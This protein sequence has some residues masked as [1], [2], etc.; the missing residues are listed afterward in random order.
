MATEDQLVPIVLSG[1]IDTKTDPKSVTLDKLLLL[2]NGS[3][4]SPK[5]I[6]KRNGYTNLGNATISGGNIGLSVNVAANETALVQYA[7]NLVYAQTPARAAFAP[8]GSDYPITCKNLSLRNSFSNNDLPDYA[9]VN[10]YE[11]YSYFDSSLG[12]NVTIRDLSTS[13]ILFESNASSFPG[14]LAPKLIS[15]GSFAYLFESGTGAGGTLTITKIDPTLTSPLVTTVTAGVQTNSSGAPGPGSRPVFEDFFDAALTT[16][17][18]A[19]AFF[20]TPAGTTLEVQLYDQA[21]TLTQS[22]TLTIGVSAPT[23]FGCIGIKENPVTGEIYVVYSSDNNLYYYVLSSTLT[24]VIGPVLIYTDTSFSGV[25]QFGNVTAYPTGAN[26]MTVL[27]QAVPN[28]LPSITD[29][30]KNKIY[31]FNLSNS[32]VTFTDLTFCKQGS[33]ASKL[34]SYGGKYYVVEGYKSEVQATYYLNEVTLTGVSDINKLGMAGRFLIGTAQGPVG[35]GTRAI[36]PEVTVLNGQAF[37]GLP[38]QSSLGV[39]A[40]TPIYATTKE[41]FNFIDPAHVS[42]SSVPDG[43]IL[44]TNAQVQSFDGYNAEENFNKFP[45]APILT[46]GGAGQLD[47]GT[48]QVAVVYEWSDKLGQV[49][50]S[51]PSIPTSIT[52]PGPNQAIVVQMDNTVNTTK[53][54]PISMGVYRTIDNGTVFYR[55]NNTN[56]LSRIANSGSSVTTV[57]NVS[58]ADIQSHEILYTDGGILPNDPAPS[59]TFQWQFKNRTML[60]GLDDGNQVAYSKIQVKGEPVKFNANFFINV[61][62]AGGDTTAGGQ[63]DDKCILFKKSKIFYFFGDGPTDAG[64]GGSFSI[65]QEVPSPV[66]CA[67]P[68]SVVSTPFGLMFKSEKGIYL[69]DRNLGTKYIGADVEAFNSANVTSA[70]HIQTKNQVR[71][72]LDSGIVLMYDY[73]VNQWSTFTNIAA[74][75]A[76]LSNGV[77]SYVNSDGTL[78]EESNGF[79][80]DTSAIIMKIGLPW[81]KMAGLQGFQRAK[82][83]MLLGDYK[84]SHT[85]S[86]QIAFDYEDA[87]TEPH[88][89]VPDSNLNQDG[90]DGV[91]QFRIFLDRQKCESL[92]VLIFDNFPGSAGEGYSLSELALLIGVKKGLNKLSARKTVV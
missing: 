63:M 3:F 70:V 46:V 5:R 29:D 22:V 33:L 92:R 75:G 62:A 45:E 55:E 24:P 8:V 11:L 38:V 69:L 71:F 19:T 87:F 7:D 4:D 13:A 58:D 67:Y 28:I 21:L 44:T 79:L 34:F 90:E 37:V 39:Q 60:G 86:V 89:W 26:Q 80:D 73:Y 23:W 84:S 42:M 85:L 47:A 83:L 17:G 56:F 6:K 40:A 78:H 54:T 77:Y 50:R 81:I 10:G 20:T 18:L 76:T 15:W 74:V 1:G 32:G 59:C 61:N 68:K 72:S 52:I 65:P 49:H 51:T 35:Q 12:P 25:G 41:T 66:G 91:D 36:L 64:A 27:A 88:L 14:H 82:Q 9:I 30:Q 16:S 43:N 2:E 57:G 31:K 48:Y 53:Q